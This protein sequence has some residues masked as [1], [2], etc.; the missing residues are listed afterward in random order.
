ML[1]VGRRTALRLR[2]RPDPGEVAPAPRRRARIPERVQGLGRA[3]AL[4]ID[5]DPAVLQEEQGGAPSREGG[6]GPGRA[7]ALSRLLG[8]VREA[9]GG[10]EHNRRRERGHQRQGSD[11]YSPLHGTGREQVREPVQLARLPADNRRTWRGPRFV[12]PGS[13]SARR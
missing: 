2:G 9:G 3:R 6:A 8:G 1:Q 5:D 13:C 11:G 4:D 12:G 10:A 7:A